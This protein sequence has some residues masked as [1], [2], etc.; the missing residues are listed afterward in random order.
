MNENATSTTT[1]TKVKK[2]ATVPVADV[3]FGNVVTSVSNKWATNNWLVLKWLTATNFNTDAVAY[4]TILTNRIQQGASRPQ[5]T[6]ALKVLDKKMDD[7]LIYVKGY[8]VDKYKKENATSYYASFGIEYKNNRYFFPID[9]NNRLIAIAQMIDALTTN[10]FGTKEFGVAFWTPIQTE[11]KAL[12]Q[13]A[14]QTDGSVATKVG[15]KNKLRQSLN[16]GLNAILNALK[17]NYP[18]TYKQE[19]RDWGFQKEKY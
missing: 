16:K 1:Q 8:I 18:D 7:A 4:N 3:N 14:T 9:Q 17:A 2:T 15:D 12:I 6:K 11:Y 19:L 10:G 5:I 13:S